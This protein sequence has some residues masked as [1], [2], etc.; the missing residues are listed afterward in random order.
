MK[1]CLTREERKAHTYIG[2]AE[3]LKKHTDRRDWLVAQAE[4]AGFVVECNEGFSISLS[5]DTSPELWCITIYEAGKLDRAATEAR[6]ADL[7]II[8][9]EYRR[10]F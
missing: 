8:F 7:R 1:T 4:A 2:S 9:A 6:K 3:I 10:K 5:G